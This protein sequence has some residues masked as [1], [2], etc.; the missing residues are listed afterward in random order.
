MDVMGDH[1][2]V[3]VGSGP[4]GSA[5]AALLGQQGLRVA[6][7]EAHR[8]PGHYKRLCTH[9]IQSSAL[10][11]LQRLGLDTALE[12]AGAVPNGLH[13]WTRYGWIH[14]PPTDHR[15]AHGYNVRRQTL[16]PLMRAAAA[17][18]A[19]V[20]LLLGAKV[21]G[22]SRD[23]QGR[24]DGVLARVDGQQQRIGARLVVGADGKASRVAE[25]AG[26]TPKESPNGRFGYFAQYRGISLPAGHA[27]QMWQRP[28]DAAYLFANEDGVTVVA[29]M[30][31]KQR[32]GDFA[33]DRERALLAC[34]EGFPDVPDL[35]R[36]ERVSD[37]V[38]T[39]DYPSLTRRRVAGPGVALLG[40]AA[41]VGDPLWGVGCGFALQSAG[42]LA[43]AAAEALAT[44]D[45]ASL[46]R[47]TRAYGRTHRRRLGLHQ[48][49]LV[50]ASSGRDFN[51]LERL[52]YA[53]AARDPKVAERVTRYG[54]RNASPL[55]LFSPTLLVRAAAARR[56]GVPG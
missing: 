34:F 46:D 19:G 53:G 48:A 44:G 55:T 32:L 28:P 39:Q 49:M 29:A 51:A 20:D 31:G 37:I 40:D 38:G 23:Q 9:Y 27:V 22:L 7:L 45:D 36:A 50:D 16:D 26:L 25:S 11:V 30:P 21:T 42:W 47:A 43:D 41:M 3:V 15:P 12:A 4:A 6:L 8:D 24:V 56:A 54:S 2:A 13:M 1:H 14:E 17:D 10:P 18:T 33:D 35:S 5:A 52:L